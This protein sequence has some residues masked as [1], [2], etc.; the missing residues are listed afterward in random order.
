MR[1][2][3]LSLC[4]FFCSC[5][6]S[7]P[8]TYAF[9]AEPL[10]QEGWYA[11]VYDKV[12]DCAKHFDAFNGRRYSELDWFIVRAGGLGGDTIGTYSP[13]NRI[14]LDARYVMNAGLIQHELSH[15]LV[16]P[17]SNSEDDPV[18]KICAGVI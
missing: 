10:Q 3:L 7:A 12:K 8:K 9:Y 16:K 15:A 14:Y 6:A 13:P 4:I 18:F 1:T 2:F 17:G 5:C 11:T